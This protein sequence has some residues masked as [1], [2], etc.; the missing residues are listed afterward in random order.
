MYVYI[1]LYIYIYIYLY[2][3]LFIFIPRRAKMHL[4]CVTCKEDSQTQG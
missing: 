2:L 3:Y 1:T 4:K